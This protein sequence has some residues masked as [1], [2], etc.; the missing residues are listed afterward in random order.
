MTIAMFGRLNEVSVVNLGDGGRFNRGSF[1]FREEE[2]SQAEMVDV[3]Y[4]IASRSIHYY[5][6]KFGADAFPRTADA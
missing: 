3:M 4:D 6:A 1:F 2:W 5:F